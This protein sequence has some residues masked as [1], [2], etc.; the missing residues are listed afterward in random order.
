[1]QTKSALKVLGTLLFLLGVLGYIF[2]HWP[3]TFFSNNENLFHVL[4]GLITLMLA[5][6]SPAFR[7]KSLFWLAVLF[8]AIGAFGFFAGNP[9]FVQ[10]KKIAFDTYLNEADNYIHTVFALAFAWF[11]LTNRTRN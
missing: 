4:A 1:M 7:L 9:E 10:I 11:W 5:S 3:Q 2:P 8:L 6:V